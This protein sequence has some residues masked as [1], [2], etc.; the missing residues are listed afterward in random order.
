MKILLTGYK[1]FIGSNLL[2]A[3]SDHEVSVYEWGDQRIDIN[4]DVCIHIGAISSTAE[5]N[6]E[7]IMQQ[8]YEFS[9]WLLDTCNKHGVDF[10][11]SSSAS[12]YGLG[13]NFNE[14]APVDPK[15]PY[16]WSKYLFERYA[17]SKHCN[18]S[19]QGFRYFNVYGP[20]EEHKN[21]QA[22]PYHKFEKQAKSGV[23]TLFENSEEYKRDF[24]HVSSVCDAHLKFLYIKKSGIWNVGTGSTKSFLDVANEVNINHNA[25][26]EYVPMPELMKASYQKYTCAN[27]EKFNKTI[28]S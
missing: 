10:Q 26:I 28:L 8:N 15:T 1:G 27:M 19:V 16:A 3:L 21:D 7:K 23:I 6:V 11:Y 25:R 24:I 22:S 12:I 9:V 5:R 20:G 18:V 13:D 14:T 4:V 2:K 17:T